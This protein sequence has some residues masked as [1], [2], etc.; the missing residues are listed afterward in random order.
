MEITGTGPGAREGR[1][2]W[3]NGDVARWGWLGRSQNPRLRAG[4]SSRGGVEVWGR[5][6]LQGILG[7]FLRSGEGL[8]GAEF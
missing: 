3:P 8:E 1:L 6:C 7:D 5:W 4:V 2:S